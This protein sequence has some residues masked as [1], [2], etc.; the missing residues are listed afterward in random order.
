MNT[1]ENNLDKE[2][3]MRFKEKLLILFI[4]VIIS[5]LG[6]NLI[7]SSSV[8]LLKVA[9]EAGYEEINSHLTRYDSDAHRTMHLDDKVSL[10]AHQKPDPC[11][12]KSR[13]LYREKMNLLQGEKIWKQN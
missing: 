6:F 7:A 13:Y 12:S 9:K 2:A 3:K 5:L 11:R 8:C 4:A 1:N 10:L